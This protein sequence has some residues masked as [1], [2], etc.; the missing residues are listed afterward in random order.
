MNQTNQ[1]SMGVQTPHTNASVLKSVESLLLGGLLSA[2]HKNAA[3]HLPPY[4]SDRSKA[5][6][7]AGSSLKGG[8]G[9][10]YSE[11][12]EISSCEYTHAEEQYQDKSAI[13]YH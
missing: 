2:E 12:P 7:S 11:T 1:V 10:K 8:E 4:T 3:R 13:V 6:S 9:A 5:T